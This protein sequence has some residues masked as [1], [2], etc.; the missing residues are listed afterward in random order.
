M[1]MVAVTARLIGVGTDRVLAVLRAIVATHARSLGAG[2]EAVAVLAARCVDAGMQRRQLAG[3]AALA[4]VRRRRREAAVAMAGLARDL[5]DVRDV[6]GA[7]RD[8]VIRRRNLLR[9]AVFAGRAA[10]DREH[11]HHERAHH[12][13]DPI[14]WHSRHGIDDSGT[15]LDQPAGWGLPPT[16]PTL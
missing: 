1:C 10:P 15:R 12:G 3:V 8:L 16:P 6:T 13:R 9:D 2:G 7:R 11:D 14:G 5:A 4:D